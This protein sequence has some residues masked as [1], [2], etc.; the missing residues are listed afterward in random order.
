MSQKGLGK[1]KGVLSSE[2]DCS[3]PG[4]ATAQSWPRVLVTSRRTNRKIV[5]CPER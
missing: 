5:T 4:V 1:R 2:L 3:H